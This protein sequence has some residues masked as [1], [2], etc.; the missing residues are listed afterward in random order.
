MRIM[1]KTFE[2]KGK[3]ASVVQ[4]M[5]NVLKLIAGLRNDDPDVS[6][7]TSIFTAASYERIK[8][9]TNYSPEAELKKSQALLHWQRFEN[10]PR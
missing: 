4:K 6:S 1:W 10:R 9:F 8:P 7:S 2:I 3:L 5:F